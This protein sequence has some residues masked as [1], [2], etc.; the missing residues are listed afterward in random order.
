MLRRRHRAF[1]AHLHS[2][3]VE[4]H[5]GVEGLQRPVLPFGHL[6][7]HRIRHRADQL[8]RDVNAIE[9]AQVALDL[10]HAQ[11]TRVERDH[12]GVEV[13]EA[14]AILG[15][16]LWLEARLA[17]ARYRELQL[18]AAAQHRLAAVAVT[19]VAWHL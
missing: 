14:A 15:D 16:Q 19:M 13:W 17:V 8:G 9:L 5:Q 4:E 11:A 6:L 18:A 1:V 12:L 3:C 7:V 10:P 2:Q